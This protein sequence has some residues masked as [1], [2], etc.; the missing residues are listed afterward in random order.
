MTLQK[1][2][3]IMT[4]LLAVGVLCY[5]LW[6]LIAGVGLTTMMENSTTVLVSRAP[7]PAAWLPLLASLAI[8]WGLWKKQAR[9]TWAGTGVLLAFSLLFLFSIGGVLL[10]P[11]LALVILGL[12]A[13]PSPP[14]DRRT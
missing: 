12:L 6:L 9:A 5:A 11:A 1:S 13:K 14:T 2:I 8:L 4:A 7:A 3:T 10:L